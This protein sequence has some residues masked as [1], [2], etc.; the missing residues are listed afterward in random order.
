VNPVAA[1]NAIERAHHYLWRFWTAFP[2]AGHV[3]IFDRSWYGRVL[4]ER[5]ERFC[6]ED[7]WRRAYGEINEMENQWSRFGT[8]VIKFWLH[9]DREEQLRRFTER[10]ETPEKMWK[11]T[12]EDWRNREKWPLYEKAVEEM[13]WRTSTPCAPWTVWRRTP[14]N[15]PGSKCSKPL[16]PRRKQRWRNGESPAALDGPRNLCPRL[17]C[18]RG[19]RDIF[20]SLERQSSMRPSRRGLACNTTVPQ[21]ERDRSAKSLQDG[22]QVVRK[23]SRG[24]KNIREQC[25]KGNES[26][27]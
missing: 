14:R 11:I 2:K 7:A 22:A 24:R 12:E 1:P 15:T 19:K 18:R 27:A 9:I 10:S 6:S 21:L 3:A 4:V 13:L 20:R 23:P 16:S 26:E 17:F 5:V 8:V 25:R